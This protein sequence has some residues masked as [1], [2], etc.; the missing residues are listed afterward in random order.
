MR[1]IRPRRMTSAGHTVRTRKMISGCKIVVGQLEGGGEG[2]RQS[3]L[4]KGRYDNK[5]DCKVKVKVKLFLCLTKHR[6]MKTYWG[7]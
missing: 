7:S 1:M 6:A 3:T 5:M 2:K 4:E